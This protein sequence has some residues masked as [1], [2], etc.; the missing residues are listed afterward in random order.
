MQMEKN[1]F[2]YDSD[3]TSSQIVHGVTHLELA[4]NAQVINTVTYEQTVDHIQAKLIEPVIDE[5]DASKFS[6]HKFV[7]RNTKDDLCLRLEPCLNIIE[8]YVLYIS[9]SESP[10][11]LDYDIKTRI[12]GRN[13]WIACIKASVMNGHTGMNY[14]GVETKFKSTTRYVYILFV[15]EMTNKHFLHISQTSQI[16]R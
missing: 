4:D 11:M 7:Y 3:S 8:E 14:L 5:E 16:K 10:T 9:F 13:N 6:Y 12:S 2:M 15:K 1:I